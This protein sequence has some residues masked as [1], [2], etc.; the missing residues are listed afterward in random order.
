MK[1][2]EEF[3]EY[4]GKISKK[5]KVMVYCGPDSDSICSSVLFSK[6]FERQNGRSI[7]YLI[8]EKT[9]KPGISEE[10][11][12]F[13]QEN[14]INKLIVLDIAID[15]ADKN[16]LEELTKYDTLV[17]DHH[18]IVRDLSSERILFIKPNKFSDIASAQYPTS[19]IVFDLASD[20][21]DVHDLDWICSI[22]VIADSSYKTWKDF[23]DQVVQKYKLRSEENIWQSD[24]G[25]ISSYLSSAMI[26]DPSNYKECFEILSK[27]KQPREVLIS[28]LG[29]FKR[30]V[31]ICI[32][33]L[34]KEFSSKAEAYS[35]LDLVFYQIKP[36]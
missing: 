23:V 11:K 7:D 12:R 36:K 25:L 26:V 17:I 34:I 30:D 31:D 9:N 20:F 24:L 19:K 22:G 8:A 4:L 14:K 32:E 6:I 28:D 18:Q 2:S 27:S 33:E 29:R 3:K 21:V 35:D 13:L 1:I 16:T 15:N 10:N 5:D